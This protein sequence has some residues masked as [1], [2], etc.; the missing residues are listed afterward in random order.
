LSQVTP[1]AVATGEA[2]SVEHPRAYG[3]L[4]FLVLLYVINYVDRQILS[5]LLVPI[6]QD[7]GASDTQMGLLTGLAFA[8]FYTFAAIPIARLAD[9]GVRKTVIVWGVAVWSVMTATCG[10]ARS[11]VELALAR[12]GVG[13]GEATLN[14]AAHSLLSDYFPASKRA[15]ALAL[16]NVGGNLGIMAGFMLGGL[17][18]ER[19]GWR[20]AFLVVGLPGLLA[21]IA[22]RF[23]LEE[24]PRSGVAGA[25][26]E[27]E[28]ATTREVIAFMLGQRTFRHLCLASALYAFAAYGFTI[29][30]STFLIRVHHMSLS[31]TGIAM[32]LGQGIG[33]GVGTYL[34]GRASDARAGRDAR[35][36]LLVAAFGGALALPFLAL[37]L[38]LPAR[39]AAL[40]AYSIAMVFS[41]FFVGPSYGLAQSLARVRMRAQAAALLLFA[42]NLIGLGIAPLVVGMLNDGLAARF[43]DEAIRYSLLMTGAT[44][45]WAVVHSLLASRSVRADLEAMRKSAAGEAGFARPSAR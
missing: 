29:W 25:A 23:V 14:P 18:G 15:T 45:L 27:A 12:V 34:G 24:P 26:V 22:T 32:G 17:I 38:M 39:D 43:G 42:I 16:Y 44:T 41:V 20:S 36:P 40:A 35:A 30:G 7:L 5:V 3:M 28:V 13:A 6:K 31:D 19:L 8:L 37:F 33:G 4:A 1:Q 11:F 9:G 21:A 10:F 2:T